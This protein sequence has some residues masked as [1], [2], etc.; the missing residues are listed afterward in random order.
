MNPHHHLTTAQEAISDGKKKHADPKIDLLMRG[1]RGEKVPEE[2]AYA[3]DKFRMSYQRTVLN[4]L[5]IGGATTEQI[6]QATEIPFKAIAAYGEYIF[7]ITVFRDLLERR[8]WVV[9]M[10]GHLTVEEGKILMAALTTGVRYLIWMLSG[11]GSYTPAEVLR[12]TMN[13]AQFRSLAHRSA[14]INSDVSKEAHQWA[15]TAERLARSVNAV[16]PQDNEEAR[17]QLFIALNHEDDTVDEE[18]SGIPKADIL[19]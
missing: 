5:F 1:L 16:D 14:T 6:H 15:R 19:H 13:D 4:A 7:D 17:K 11:R 9:S 2:L 18:S 12:Q 8:S 3:L 10:Q